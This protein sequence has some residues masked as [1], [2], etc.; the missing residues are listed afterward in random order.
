MQPMAQH[1]LKNRGTTTPIFF[2][3]TSQLALASLTQNT[4]NQWY[5]ASFT[6]FRVFFLFSLTWSTEYLRTSSPRYCCL[7]CN[8][9]RTLYLIQRACLPYGW[10]IIQRMLYFS[11]RFI[12][13]G[14]QE[15]K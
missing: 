7:R 9:L 5:V 14:A 12:G 3:W 4:A 11:D 2:L 13:F 8:L 10:R 6:R 15:G 1:S